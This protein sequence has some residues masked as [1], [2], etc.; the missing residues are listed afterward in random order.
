MFVH[1]LAR[2]SVE[3]GPALGAVNSVNADIQRP[4]SFFSSAA[5]KEKTPLAF[6]NSQNY[7]TAERLVKLKSKVLEQRHY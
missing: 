4:S 1:S 2:Q 3:T 6:F 7:I 5:W